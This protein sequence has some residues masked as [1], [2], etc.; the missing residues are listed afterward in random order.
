MRISDWSSDVFSSDLA[1]LAYIARSQQMPV[2]MH[3]MI[4]IAAEIL[5]RD[6]MVKGSSAFGKGDLC[7]LQRIVMPFGGMALVHVHNGYRCG[8]YKHQGNQ[9]PRPICKGLGHLCDF[10]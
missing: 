5:V 4:V 2:Q 3:K 7:Q 6:D 8:Q 9:Y 1:D 10:Q